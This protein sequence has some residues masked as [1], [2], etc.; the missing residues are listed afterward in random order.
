MLTFRCSSCGRQIT[1]SDSHK[2]IACP[3]CGFSQE[4]HNGNSLIRFRLGRTAD[5]VP[6]PGWQ[7]PADRSPLSSLGDHEETPRHLEPD[8]E[9]F[10]APF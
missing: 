5:P 9:Y 10:K 2:R 4:C 3:S 8:L 6:G 7:P 1:T